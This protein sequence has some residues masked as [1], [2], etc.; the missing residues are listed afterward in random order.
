MWVCRVGKEVVVWGSVPGSVESEGVMF[1][2]VFLDVPVSQVLAVYSLRRRV[3]SD[4]VDLQN[5][6]LMILLNEEMGLCQ[7]P[8]RVVV[9]FLAKGS[10]V[11][12]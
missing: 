12:Q 8:V 10:I 3:P 5:L 4:D 11:Q 1:G 7:I 2:W 6:S 9:L